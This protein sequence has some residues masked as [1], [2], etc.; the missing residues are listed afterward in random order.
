MGCSDTLQRQPR[1]F[2]Q[3]CRIRLCC[4]GCTAGGAGGPVGA[5]P[6]DQGPRDR[7][8]EPR[9]A[10]RDARFQANAHSRARIADMLANGDSPAAIMKAY[11]QLDEDRIRLAAV[12]ALAH[13][14]RGRPRTKSPWRSRLPI[15]SETLAVIL[16]SPAPA[17]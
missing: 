14:S 7:V 11:P 16:Y 6:F 1:R 4:R 15:A 2:T 10:R 8:H 3:A 12:Y 13:P 9:R 17:Q 5:Q